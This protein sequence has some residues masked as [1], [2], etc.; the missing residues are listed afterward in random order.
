MKVWID[1]LYLADRTNEGEEGTNCG[2]ESQTRM[3]VMC[4][5]RDSEVSTKCVWTQILKKNQSFSLTLN[6]FKM[7]LKG[8]WGVGG[9][10]KILGT[11]PILNRQQIHR[12]A[13]SVSIKAHS[14]KS[15]ITE[16]KSREGFHTDYS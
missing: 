8:I 1:S 7:I 2:N 9:P 4:V 6:H 15:V 5:P 16:G 3:R 10:K 11:V 14:S 13:E 12:A